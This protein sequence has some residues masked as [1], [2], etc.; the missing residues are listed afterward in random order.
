MTTHMN[1]IN[2]MIVPTPHALIESYGIDR[3]KAE[4]QLTS[5]SRVVDDVCQMF[6]AYNAALYP[7][8]Q[9][10]DAKLREIAMCISGVRKHVESL[11][12]TGRTIGQLPESLPTAEDYGN[13]FEYLTA[14][15]DAIN[16]QAPDNTLLKNPSAVR[17]WDY[18]EWQAFLAQRHGDDMPAFINQLA[19]ASAGNDYSRAG[20]MHP[21]RYRDW[22]RTGEAVHSLL[23]GTAGRSPA[24]TKALRAKLDAIVSPY[25]SRRACNEV[26]PMLAQ[27]LISVA[28]AEVLVAAGWTEAHSDQVWSALSASKIFKDGYGCRDATIEVQAV[29]FNL[30][31]LNTTINVQAESAKKAAAVKFKEEQ[32]SIDLETRKAQAAALLALQDKIRAGTVTAEELDAAGY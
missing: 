10:H 3:I 6:R 4:L 26:L 21:S 11:L 31:R 20:S 25:Y 7:G 13:T 16:T 28:D 2:A 5:M 18:P 32:A 15:V 24:M 1:T 30:T 12:E 27:N 9:Q 14:L 29:Q 19:S 23:F 8:Q 22:L 17:G